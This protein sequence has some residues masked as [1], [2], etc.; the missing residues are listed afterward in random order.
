MR[1]TADSNKLAKEKKK[2][3]IQVKHFSQKIKA[4]KDQE[5]QWEAKHRNE[6]L[7]SKHINNHIKPKIKYKMAK[8]TTKCE[9]IRLD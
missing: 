3:A 8:H 7:K 9:T 6:S 4:W 5:E 2:K 1:L